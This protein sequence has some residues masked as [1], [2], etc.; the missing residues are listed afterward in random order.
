MAIERRYSDEEMRAIFERASKTQPEGERPPRSDSTDGLTLAQLQ[1]IGREVGIPAELVADAAKELDR[2]LPT[3]NV[4]RLAG[5]PVGVG[6]TVELGR[7]L[8]DEEWDRLVAELRETFNARGV[9]RAEGGLRQWANGNL[10][11]F[12]EPSQSGYRLRLRTVKAQAVALIRMGSMFLV[13]SALFALVAG[14]GGRPDKFVGIAMLAAAGVAAIGFAALSVPG[15]ARVRA[16][17]MELIAE[18]A[19]ELAR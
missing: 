5:L 11:A 18:R 17:Q 7:R 15:W 2:P 16:R 6:R 9:V 13:G 19:S 10:Q 12:L 8:T 4:S 14:L 1:E 3:T